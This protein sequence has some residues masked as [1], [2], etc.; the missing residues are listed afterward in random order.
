MSDDEGLRLGFL[1]PGYAAEDDYPAMAGRLRP[2]A[3]VELVHTTVGVD[4]HSVEALRDLGSHDRLAAGA[5]TLCERGPDV[6][7]W[8]CTSG[9]FVFGHDGATTQVQRLREACGVPASSTSFAFLEATAALGLDTVAVAATYP[10]PVAERFAEFLQAGDVEVVHVGNAGIV[11]A[12]AVGRLS[13]DAVRQLVIANR[14]PRAQ[15][16]LVPDTAMH[17]AAHLDALETAAGLPVLTANQVTLWQALE[18][19][20]WAGEAHGLGSLFG[21]APPGG[22]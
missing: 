11:T 16:L 6:V 15:A 12:T 20:G 21:Q 4:E 3:T 9:S 17:T 2:T 7:V 14:H 19:A 1:Y 5:A 22:H 10:A 13:P 18:L 8:A